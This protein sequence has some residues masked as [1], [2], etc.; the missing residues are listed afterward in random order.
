MNRYGMAFE[1]SFILLRRTFHRDR[2]LGS[3]SGSGS[4][5]GQGAGW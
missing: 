3:G 4:G 2:V 5:K 1:A